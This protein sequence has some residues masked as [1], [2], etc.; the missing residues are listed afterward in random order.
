MSKTIEQQVEE[1]NEKFYI[2]YNEK[3]KPTEDWLRTTLQERDRTAYEEGHIAG[4]MVG[5]GLDEAYWKDEIEKATLIARED[6]IQNAIK[7]AEEQERGNETEFNEW[8]AFKGFRNAL[9]DRLKRLTTPLEETKKRIAET[10]IN[11]HKAVERAAILGTEEQNKSLEETEWE[12]R[13]RAGE[14][15]FDKE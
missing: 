7:I 13:E 12:A 11:D 2:P 3:N 1:F 15:P 14:V 9:H 8:R 4:V 10:I 6:E 5:E